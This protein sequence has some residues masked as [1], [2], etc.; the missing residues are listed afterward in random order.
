[1]RLGKGAPV[2]H[3]RATQTAARDPYGRA[4]GSP[5]PQRL[6]VNSTITWA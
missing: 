3:L 6:R 4:R 5:A 2:K 1:M